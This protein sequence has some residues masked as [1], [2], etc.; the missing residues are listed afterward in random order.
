MIRIE[1]F[2]DVR[3]KGLLLNVYL[4]A[5]YV[6]SVDQWGINV[7]KATDWTGQEVDLTRAEAAEVLRRLLP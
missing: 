1:K 4:S 7:L 5:E 6:R 2:T 3:R